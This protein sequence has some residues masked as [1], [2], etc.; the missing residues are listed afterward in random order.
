M[1]GT[2][3]VT[4]WGVLSSM[5]VGAGEFGKALADG[6]SGLREVGSEFGETLPRS[7]AHV[8]AGFDVRDHLGR[9]RT[10]SLDRTTAFAVTATGLALAD[11][12]TVL[13]DESRD[14]TGVVLGNTMG[15]VRSIVEFDRETLVNERPYMVEPLLFPNSVMNCAASRCA[16]WH[17]LRGVN[18]TIPAGRISAVAA[19]RYGGTLIRRG[20]AHTLLLGAV[21]EFSAHRAWLEHS[22]GTGQASRAPLGEA[23]VVLVTEDASRVRA[24]GR[25][26]DAEILAVR[27]GHFDT[28][29]PTPAPADA[30]ARHIRAALDAAGLTHEQVATVATGECGIPGV[31]EVER[32]AVEAVF[33][34]GADRL[35]ISELAGDCASASGTMQIAAVLARHRDDPG[36]DGQVSVVTSC[37]PEGDLGVVVLRGWSRQAA[38]DDR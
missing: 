22:A 11:A 12:G 3:A 38:A 13:D 16:I 34:T 8:I 37:D 18:A 31:D 23:A 1:A 4:G 30:L 36:R 24:A 10:A 35:R 20:H 19:L 21:E 2:L 32:T 29:D 7:T 6:Q 15:S 5:G 9:K 14:E 26:L 25:P 17:Q 27:V 28:D 33:G